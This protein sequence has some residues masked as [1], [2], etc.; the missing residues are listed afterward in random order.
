MCYTYDDKLCSGSGEPCCASACALAYLG[1]AEWSLS[2]KL[3]MHRPRVTEMGD[4]S[5]ADA[6]KSLELAYAEIENYLKEMQADRKFLDAAMSAAPNSIKLVDINQ[7]A[8]DK[9]IAEGDE[10]A[11]HYY[12]Y[13]P[14]IGDWLRA[15]CQH[16]V[17][18]P[19]EEFRECM[20]NTLD[21]ERKTR[22]DADKSSLE[23]VGEII[24]IDELRRRM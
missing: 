24:T 5:L 6:Q 12:D 15:K 4:K 14:S 20:H 7:A 21:R 13:P 9:V 8:L 16:K 3:G 18:R 1:A 2:D 11:F 19:P 17:R 23:A 22:T 10:H